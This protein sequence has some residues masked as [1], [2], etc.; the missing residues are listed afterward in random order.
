MPARRG[1]AFEQAERLELYLVAYAGLALLLA[2][3]V[4]PGLVSALTP[5]PARAIFTATREALLTAAIVGDQFVVLP[6]L[7]ASCRE[8]VARHGRADAQAAAMPDVIVPASYNFPHSGKLLSVSFVLF[9][10]WFSD[11]T[12]APADYPRLGVTAVVTLFGSVNANRRH[13]Y[14][15]N[16]HLARADHSWL[17]RLITR[18]EPPKR[19]ARALDRQPEDVKVIIEFGDV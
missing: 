15:A 1:E 12:I 2:L 13:W 10:A 11:A 19:F 16:A 8:L 14:K 4:L 3:W 5:I 6:V 17:N 18:R 7:I 9:A